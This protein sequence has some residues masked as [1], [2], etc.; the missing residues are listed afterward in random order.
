MSRM[1]AVETKFY[2]LNELPSITDST[3]LEFIARKKSMG[4]SVFGTF[5]WHRHSHCEVSLLPPCAC[6][7]SIPLLDCLL[8]W[9][10]SS[11]RHLVVR[12]LFKSSLL[13][14]SVPGFAS[15]HWRPDSGSN[16]ST[17]RKIV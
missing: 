16:F 1:H 2:I 3:F 5:H 12:N 6:P 11:A 10:A 13:R 17:T 9:A 15:S 7:F 14:R 4:S 8:V